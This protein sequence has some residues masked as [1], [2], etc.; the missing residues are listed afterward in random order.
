MP[1][2]EEAGGLEGG[3]QDYLASPEGDMEVAAEYMRAAGYDSGKCEGSDCE[4]S[5]VGD[6]ALPDR[7]TTDVFVDALEELGFSVN[8]Q[9]VARDVMYTR[10]CGTPDSAPNV[11][12]SVGWLKDFQDPQS[13]LQPTFNGEEIQPTNNV[14]WPQLD[15][16][17]IN[18][19]MDEAAL[20]DDEDERAQAWGDI[21]T[22]IVDQAAA[23]PY[24]WDN[25]V[26]IKSADVA[27]VINLFNANWDLAYTSLES[28]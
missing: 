24:V 13:I 18:E 17:E 7:D 20:I 21:D 28:P 6:G 26:N 15:V 2:Y 22:Q 27:G 4:V 25:Q 8:E 14:N 11:C 3:G 1:G 12:P 19:A 5:V 10:F 9:G 16:P 23:V